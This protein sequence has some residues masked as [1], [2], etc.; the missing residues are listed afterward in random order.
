MA[1]T[2]KNPLEEVD[3]ASTFLKSLSPTLQAMLVTEPC[4]DFSS[5][6]KVA[7]RIEHAIQDGLVQ[8]NDQPLE[9]TQRELEL[10]PIASIFPM[11]SK[12]QVYH[13]TQVIHTPAAQV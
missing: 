11:N 4:D 13:S 1:L 7:S 2:L 10:F 8:D 6:I 5:M 9:I 3:M 12:S